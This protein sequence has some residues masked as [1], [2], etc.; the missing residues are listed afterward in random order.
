MRSF[1]I[2]V[3]IFFATTFAH[4]ET[5]VEFIVV[6]KVWPEHKWGHVSLRVKDAETDLVFDFGRYG[7]MWGLF[8]SQGE[9]ILRVWKNARSHLDA[10]REG[11][12]VIR[13]IRFPA[14]SAQA[15][16]VLKYFEGLSGAK[17]YHRSADADW[18]HISSTVFHPINN[19]CVTMAIRGFMRG[20]PAI[21][22]NRSSYA[23]GDGLY[24]WARVKARGTS[25]NSS[26]KTWNHVWWPQDLLTLLQREYV[27]KGLAVG[28][29]Y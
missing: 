14:T 23:K 4:A 10:Q 1:L 29:V 17:L 5:F 12:P 21:N 13:A 11:G 6:G 15:Q 9:A 22:V 3:V 20:L 24:V 16:S 8:N 26:R 19:N 7:R 18:Y 2:A 25:Y 27:A 28:K